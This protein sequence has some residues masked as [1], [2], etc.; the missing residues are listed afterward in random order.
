MSQ[1][2]RQ[3]VSSP[4]AVAVVSTTLEIPDSGSTGNSKSVN[5]PSNNS[6]VV[7]ETNCSTVDGRSKKSSKHKRRKSISPDGI[8]I[9]SIILSSPPSPAS[10]PPT[11]GTASPLPPAA[12]PL[13]ASTPAATTA[14]SGAVIFSTL[15]WTII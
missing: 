15:T 6:L 1:A 12:S 8:I 13:H 3:A 9:E 14:P 7:A 5:G 2:A 11:T 4:G 10:A